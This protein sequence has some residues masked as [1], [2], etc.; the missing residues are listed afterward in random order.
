M[1]KP[2][3]P[4]SMRSSNSARMPASLTSLHDPRQGLPPLTKST[5]K[6][7]VRRGSRYTNLRMA[8]KS[9]VPVG[10]RC[11]WLGDEHA[12]EMGL[13]YLSARTPIVSMRSTKSLATGRPSQL[14]LY[15]IIGNVTVTSMIDT[16]C[17][18]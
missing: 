16:G 4:T 7:V 3:L 5:V 1:S 12:G 15:P 13:S 11:S 9:L 18:E 6:P 2:E 14:R 17:S 10:P 8:S